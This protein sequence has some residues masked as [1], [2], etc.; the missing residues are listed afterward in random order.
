MDYFELTMI[1]RNLN[2]ENN[3]IDV[4]LLC[5]YMSSILESD[6]TYARKWGYVQQIRI[7]LTST[8]KNAEDKEYILSLSAKIENF[9]FIKNGW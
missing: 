6:M 5:S 4:K 2:I 9:R 8:K 7:N 1:E 3:N